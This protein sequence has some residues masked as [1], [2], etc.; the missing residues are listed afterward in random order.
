MNSTPDVKQ[1]SK[2]GFDAYITKQ[3][4]NQPDIQLAS[5]VLSELKKIYT[6]SE[7]IRQRGSANIYVID[8][9]NAPSLLLE[10]GY[11]NN[12]RTF[13]LLLMKVTRKK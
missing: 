8:E 12:Q 2:S 6:T 5:S 11:I 4:Y 13:L 10:C 7:E 9:A 3:R 1:N